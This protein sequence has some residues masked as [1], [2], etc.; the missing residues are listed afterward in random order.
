MWLRVQEGGEPAEN[1]DV[2]PQPSLSRQNSSVKR[3]ALSPYRG[4]ACTPPPRR[5]LS[6]HFW[7]GIGMTPLAAAR[8]VCTAAPMGRFASANHSSRAD[9]ST[10]QKRK[11]SEPGDIDES[12]DEGAALRKRSR[13][14]TETAKDGT[15]EVTHEELMEI[16]K[17]HQE[18]APRAV[19]PAKSKQGG[20]LSALGA[21]DLQFNKL[22][23]PTLVKHLRE[24]GLD[25]KGTKQALFDRLKAH[26]ESIEAGQTADVDVDDV[27]AGAGDAAD[28]G[29]AGDDADGEAADSEAVDASDPVPNHESEA[30]GRQL[31]WDAGQTP[32]FS[33]MNIGPLRQECRRFGLD[34]SGTRLVMIERLAGYVSQRE[35][36][37]SAEE[38]GEMGD[39]AADSAE[40]GEAAA[41]AAAEEAAAKAAAEEAAA[42]EAPAEEEA[43]K[44]AAEEEV[45]NE[46]AEEE[47]AEVA[48]EEAAAGAAA[49]EAAAAEAA[50]AA[51]AEAAATAAAEAAAA[52][53]AAEEAAAEEAA[54]EE[55]AA[56]EA[57]A[58]AAA[59]EE[60]AKAAAEEEVAKA[61]AEEAVRMAAEEMAAKEARRAKAARIAAEAKAAEEAAKIKAAAE[62]AARIAAAEEEA[63]AV[64]EAKVKAAEEEAAKAA[65][66]AAVEEAARIAAEEA[67]AKAAA[68]E[69]A[70][71]AAAAKEAARLAEEK[72][73]EAAEAAEA[74]AIAAAAEVEMDEPDVVADDEG[75]ES[76]ASD[77]MDEDEVEPADLG[78]PPS[79]PAPV[80][81]HAEPIA[82][83]SPGLHAPASESTPG[84]GLGS[85]IIGLGSKIINMG[86]GAAPS[87][88]VD[89]KAVAASPTSS[90][91]LQDNAGHAMC[92]E[93]QRMIEA[94]SAPVP[95]ASPGDAPLAIQDTISQCAL[96]A[97]DP[98]NPA[99]SAGVGASGPSGSTSDSERGGGG[100]GA[101]A[102][103]D[104]AKPEEKRSR[105]AE[106]KGKF[107]QQAAHEAQKPKVREAAAAAKAGPVAQAPRAAA[108]GLTVQKQKAEEQ[109]R[110]QAEAQQRAAEQQEAA[111]RK[112]REKEEREEQ[113]RAERAKEKANELKRKQEEEQ[114]KRELAAKNRKALEEEE[115]AKQKAKQEDD[116]AK[117]RK[118]RE[119]DDSGKQAKAKVATG[120]Q[121]TRSAAPAATSAAARAPPA[122]PDGWREYV[123]PK[124]KRPYYVSADNKTTTW[125]RPL[126]LQSAGHDGEPDSI[127]PLDKGESDSDDSP[128]QQSFQYPS[129][130]WN[131]ALQQQLATQIDQ[132][133]G[134]VFGVELHNHPEVINLGAVFTGRRFAAR[135]PSG[136]WTKDRLT[137]PE[138]EGYRAA[139]GYK[140]LGD[141]EDEPS[142]ENGAGP[143]S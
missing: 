127:I 23:R 129:W 78:P 46:A 57:A 84:K 31:P 49:A 4:G 50:E 14:G 47:E 45:A 141:P 52:T 15:L 135:G 117:K 59:E 27:E 80:P 26:L 62:E 128:E 100:D 130:T 118:G 99:D 116:D 32:K 86:S 39:C 76:G 112:L 137:Q 107:E 106:M 28:D 24:A 131:A 53:A 93:L 96:A 120:G 37:G 51:A 140:E 11:S 6:V 121:P 143:S 124:S 56:E 69:A 94:K 64:E 125:T 103:A 139:M 58:K 67:T 20:S 89:V 108:S 68:E 55:A 25:E 8:C 87:S 13:D 3:V 133:G 104:A 136:N 22:N 73:A 126:P 36:V 132:D 61:A 7:N 9:S 115:K 113:V 101:A 5:A 123:D 71:E 17:A 72:A 29:A 40:Q 30:P 88:G 19:A 70:A 63:K 38:D 114:R 75:E 105:V 41:K 102:E 74:A 16:S 43:A 77:G 92:D 79:L 82:G 1:H 111:K 33:K 122:L 90:S 138:V 34:D 44:A 142:D 18:N 98:A 35:S 85:K 134:D 10:A 81:Q 91:Y 97:V 119:D 60:A 66:A 21:A 2:N 109:K 48:A 42:E 12:A 83:A 54:A 95:R 65:E 110:K